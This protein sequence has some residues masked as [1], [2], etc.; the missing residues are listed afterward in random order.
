MTA[1]SYFADGGSI[2][3]LTICCFGSELWRVAVHNLKLAMGEG[4][5]ISILPPMI[6]IYVPVLL[7]RAALLCLVELAKCGHT[8]SREEIL[9]IADD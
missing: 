8:R 3:A 1:S 6:S 9:E 7:A 5:G 4:E 2:A